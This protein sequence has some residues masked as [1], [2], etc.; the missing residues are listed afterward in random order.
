MGLPVSIEAEFLL[1]PSEL[2]VQGNT[3]RKITRSGIS[4][5]NGIRIKDASVLPDKDS[6]CLRQHA[7]CDRGQ[8]HFE[9]SRSKIG[10]II[11]DGCVLFLLC[12][13]MNQNCDLHAV[14]IRNDEQLYRPES[15]LHG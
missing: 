2:L 5:M 15:L 3:N 6:S 13:N 12:L 4:S 7:Y 10:C 1:L 9:I 8:I 14:R 11:V